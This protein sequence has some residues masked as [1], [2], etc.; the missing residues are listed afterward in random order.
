LKEKLLWDRYF[1]EHGVVQKMPSIRIH[2]GSTDHTEAGAKKLQQ[3]HFPTGVVFRHD[4]GHIFPRDKDDPVYANVI[5]GLDDML[6][7]KVI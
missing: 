3:I 5:K 6:S 4:A 7:Q 2:G 1:V